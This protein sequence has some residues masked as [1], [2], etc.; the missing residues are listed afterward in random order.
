MIKWI[1]FDLGSTLLDETSRAQEVVEATAARLH[2]SPELFEAMLEGAARRHPYVLRKELLGG[3][4]WAP[5]PK[6]L[7]PLYP[8]VP[9]LL[10]K[11]RERCRL[12]VIANHGTGIL[13]QM[14]LAPYFDVAAVSQELGVSKPD[15][16]I[17]QLAL[18]RAGCMP[19]EALMVGDRLD[20]DVAPAKRLGMK[21]LW[22]RQGWGG[23]AVPASEEMQPDMTIDTLEE[24]LPC[25]D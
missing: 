6:R 9:E 24:L 1:F 3:V 8:G 21:T 15:P 5:W 10:Q 16:R 22:I 17:F 14:N 18:E 13:A 19:E 11:L 2:V 20:N 12:G 4:T 23:K 7:D 25:I